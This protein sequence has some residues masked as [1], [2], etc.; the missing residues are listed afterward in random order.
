MIKTSRQ[1]KDLIRNMAKETSV[2]AQILLR[3]YMMER[4]LERISV[5]EYKD[6]FIIKGGMLVASMVGLNVRSTMDIDATL[7]GANLSVT[8][9][10]VIMR[11]ITEIPIDDNVSFVIKSVSEIMDDA[12]YSGIRITFDCLFDGT[13]TPLKVDI[14][15]GDVIT[16]KEIIYPFKLMFEDRSIDVWAYNLETVIAEKLETVISRD[17]LNTRMRDFYDLYRLNALYGKTVSK[18]IL[19]A[20]LSA[21]AEKRGTVKLMSDAEKILTEIE[22]NTDMQNLWDNYRGKFSYAAD[23]SWGDVCRAVR[24]IARDAGLNVDKPSI[25]KRLH[26]PAKENAQKK[27]ISH[28]MER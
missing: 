24:T 10:E 3:N 11:D 14:S 7:K 19:S 12:E 23:I 21:T 4:L 15:I 20:A 27:P 16:P 9:M 2:N 13:K 25:V 1:L 5:S 6:K 22:D 17:V 18:D 26:E 28:Q 8:D